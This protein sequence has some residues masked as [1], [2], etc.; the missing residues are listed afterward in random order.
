MKTDPLF[1]CHCGCTEVDEAVVLSLVFALIMFSLKIFCLKN[2]LCYFVDRKPSDRNY[3]F[4]L[5]PSLFDLSGL[6]SLAS[7]IGHME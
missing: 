5:C 4:F 1:L 2:L 7:S 3:N 6:S